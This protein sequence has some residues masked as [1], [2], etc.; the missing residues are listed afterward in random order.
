MIKVPITRLRRE[1]RK[2]LRNNVPIQITRCGKAV[3]VL[4]PVEVYDNMLKM[5]G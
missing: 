3:A 2:H 1:M 4:L 5:L